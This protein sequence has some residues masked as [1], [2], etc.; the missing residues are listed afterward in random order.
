M[1]YGKVSAIVITSI[2]V[3]FS[4]KKLMQQCFAMTD[5]VTVDNDGQMREY[6]DDGLET[7]K[8]YYF[9]DGSRNPSTTAVSDMSNTLAKEDIALSSYKSKHG[10]V[11]DK[12]SGTNVSTP[13]NSRKVQT[14]HP[15]SE[16][17]TVTLFERN[18]EESFGSTS[19]VEGQLY[20]TENA[21]EE[22]TV[23]GSHQRDDSNGSSAHSG[24]SQNVSKSTSIFIK[25]NQIVSPLLA[26]IRLLEI[27]EEHKVKN[28]FMSCDLMSPSLSLSLSLSLS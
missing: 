8:N 18:D 14:N 20:D 27:I 16:T 7:H 10:A 4:F 17:R 21:H 25:Q 3:M 6:D 1:F 2:T 19:H 23:T 26:A 5:D 9:A 24:S 13:Q 28:D 12:N 22:R 11:D 15:D